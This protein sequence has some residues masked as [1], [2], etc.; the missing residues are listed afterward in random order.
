MEQTR[1]KQ[2]QEG[3]A[4]LKQLEK[5]VAGRIQNPSYFSD[6]HLSH[7]VPQSLLPTYI[8]SM[9]V[10][11]SAVHAEVTANQKKLDAIEELLQ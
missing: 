11:L 3:Q 6:G 1:L 2:L 8:S 4:R 5:G 9:S 10:F 7:S